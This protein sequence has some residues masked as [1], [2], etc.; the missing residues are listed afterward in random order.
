L[1]HFERQQKNY[2]Q[3]KYGQI[4]Q[5][6]FESRKRAPQSKYFQGFTTDY[7]RVVCKND[8]SLI[9]QIENVKIVEID[10]NGDLHGVIVT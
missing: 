10:E 4:E 9:N 3:Q 2:Q 6:L 8:E 5:V 1:A 7:Q